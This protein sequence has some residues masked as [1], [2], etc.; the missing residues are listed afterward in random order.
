[1]NVDCVT[2]IQ[3][4]IPLRQELVC[5]RALISRQESSNL[6]MI[7]ILKQLV[8]SVIPSQLHR[9][10]LGDQY[11]SGKLTFALLKF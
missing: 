1:M 2:L 4:M 6:F 5:C 10:V 7:Y 11:K 9:I 8:I 3:D